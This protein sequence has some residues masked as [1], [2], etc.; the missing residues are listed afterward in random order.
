MIID[1]LDLISRDVTLDGK[2]AIITGR[3]C[4]FATVVTL[5]RSISA[6]WTWLAAHRIVHQGGRFRRGDTQKCRCVCKLDE[7]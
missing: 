2:P 4:E 7:K 3:L 1:R 6:E 5:D